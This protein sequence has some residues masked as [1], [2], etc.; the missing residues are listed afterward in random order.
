MAPSITPGVSLCRSAPLDCLDSGRKRRRR[1]AQGGAE[2][3]PQRR[4]KPASVCRRPRRPA[5]DGTSA[6]CDACVPGLRR[7]SPCR[8]VPSPVVPSRRCD[9]VGIMSSVHAF[10][11]PDVRA[12]RLTGSSAPLAAAK[13]R[14]SPRG[15]ADEHA[16]AA[17]TAR[18]AA[19]RETSG[20]DRTHR[21]PGTLRAVPQRPRP[22]RASIHPNRGRGV[23]LR[24]APAI[25]RRSC[26]CFAICN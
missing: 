13:S 9:R 14:R 5:A 7:M 26:C 1:D 2:Q 3:Q 17:P 15:C 21:P 12:C 25:H 11:R 19:R 20:T 8:V 10:R 18:T 4:R 16:A 6:I 23:R 22:G 24:A